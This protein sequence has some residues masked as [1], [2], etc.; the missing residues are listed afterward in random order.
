MNKI[1]IGPNGRAEFKDGANRKCSIQESALLDESAFWLSVEDPHGRIL[2]TM[3][4]LQ[5]LL[6]L[7]TRF[8]ETGELRIRTHDDDAEARI[9]DSVLDGRS[10]PDVVVKQ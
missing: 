8:A 3:S 1:E 5:A 6:P 10:R 7:L 2:V 4:L 9:L